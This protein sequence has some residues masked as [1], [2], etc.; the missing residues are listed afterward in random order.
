[1]HLRHSPYELDGFR[2]S[3]H[4]TFA[5]DYRATLAL[6]LALTLAHTPSPSPSPMK[7]G[8][9]DGEESE[10]ESR[11]K[12]NKWW[13]TGWS[14]WDG[15]GSRSWKPSQESEPPRC[16]EPP[17]SN[18]TCD[19]GS[20]TAMQI[21]IP[22]GQVRCQCNKG[23]GPPLEDRPGNQCL[24]VFQP[25]A[26]TTREDPWTGE[27]LTTPALTDLCFDCHRSGLV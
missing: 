3:A 23:C 10:E 12:R 18:C 4:Q 17:R 25:T 14:G 7:R 16:T 22:Y 15:W 8:M 6:T 27:W 19:D 5:R 9:G 2:I 20:L 21:E 24:A 26:T 11:W 13:S 1:M